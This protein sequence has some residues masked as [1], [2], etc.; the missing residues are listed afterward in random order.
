MATTSFPIDVQSDH[1]EG[2]AH[3]KKPLLAI[4]ELIWNAVDADATRVDV[5]FHEDNLGKLDSIEVSDNGHGIEYQ[6]AQ[7]TFSKL[8]GSWKKGAIVSKEKRRT[9]HGKEG[10][11]RFRAL[12]LGRIADW[13]ICNSTESGYMLYRISMNKDNLKNAALT[14]QTSAPP[15]SKRGT[16]VS[17][18][19]LHRN[20]ESLTNDNARDEI[21]QIFALYLRK[22]SEVSIYYNRELVD[23]KKAEDRSD[24]IPLPSILDKEGKEHACSIEIVEW[25]IPAERRMYLCD[26]DGVPLEEIAAGIKAPGFEFT[27]YLKSSYFSILSARNMID[28]T[29]L[30]P[31]ALRSIE[32]AKAALRNHFKKRS[33]ER[34][35]SLVDQW[36]KEKIYPYLEQP[37]SEVEE[38]EQQL[39]NV[40]ALSVSRYLPDFKD[41]DTKTRKFQFTLLKQSIES[42]PSD[43]SKILN[44]VLDL[45][46]DKRQELSELL[47]RTSLSSIISASKVISDRLE[48]LQGLETLLFDPEFK[49]AL[50]ERTQLHRLVAENPW[51]FGEQYHISVDE[52]SL[53]DT[54]KKHIALMGLEVEVDTPVLRADG[55]IGRVDLMFS[56]NIQLA[57]SEEREHLIVE[58][59]RPTVIVDSKVSA[60]IESYAFAVASDERYLDS[61]TKWNFWAISNSMDE[62]TKKKVNQ[63]DRSNG[64]L[65]QSGQGENQNI[66]IWVKTWSQVISENRARLKFFA[67]QLSYTPS[68]D[69][70]LAYLKETYS[71]YLSDLF[72]KTESKDTDLEDEGLQVDR[73]TSSLSAE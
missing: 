10:R 1:I 22:Y 54:L 31:I 51:L 35:S 3:A 46:A 28:L 61:K 67:D 17:I 60:Q 55:S 2:L 45:P 72:E 57:G 37:Q 68:R 59:K 62:I 15:G 65:Y 5:S 16:T 25:H 71:K 7:A 30:D 49:P 18:S 47:N 13:N 48:F 9:L 39:F 21:T 43:L 8:G 73:M 11:G 40:L 70:S 32:S 69:S 20:Y 27:A 38:I 66:T 44:E 26:S 41:S 42:A 23:P 19:E 12:A 6:S 53:T 63:K 34:S 14:D 50:K 29:Q 33:I 24:T 4:A 58:L 52:Q 64:I 36:K 56:K